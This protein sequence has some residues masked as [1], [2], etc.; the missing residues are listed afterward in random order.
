MMPSDLEKAVKILRSNGIVA[1]P[2]ETVYGLGARL[3][4]PAVYRIYEAKGRPPD[5]PLIVHIS[6]LRQLPL[7]VREVPFFAKPLFKKFWPGPL[8]LIFKKSRK[9]HNPVIGE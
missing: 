2:T 7:L 4:D 9:I 3:S 1:F 6:S 5:N 8:T